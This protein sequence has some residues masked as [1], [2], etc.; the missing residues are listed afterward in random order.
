MQAFTGEAGMIM[1]MKS[2]KRYSS[3]KF[4]SVSRQKACLWVMLAFFACFLP[5]L[6]PHN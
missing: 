2:N 1:F 5:I 6:V 3:I 4:N